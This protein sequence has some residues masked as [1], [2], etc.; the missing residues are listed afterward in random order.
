MYVAFQGSENMWVTWVRI[1]YS[2]DAV[3]WQFLLDIHGT[4]QVNL[5]EGEE[6]EKGIEMG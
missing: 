2:T 4:P 1:A 3:D 6:V 5:R